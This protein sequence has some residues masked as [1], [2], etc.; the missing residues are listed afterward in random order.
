LKRQFLPDRVV[1][2]RIAAIEST[3]CLICAAQI[4]GIS[5][6]AME[7]FKRDYEWMLSADTR[8][9]IHLRRG[10]VDHTQHLPEKIK[11]RLSSSASITY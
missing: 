3:Q 4:C 11:Q 10:R 6:D 1:I 7:K 2:E 8:K 9:M 5:A